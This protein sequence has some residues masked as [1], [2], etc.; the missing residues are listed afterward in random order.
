MDEA[1]DNGKYIETSDTTNADLKRFREFIYR[2]LKDKKYYDD[3]HPVS[4]IPACFFDTAKTH[5][6]NAIEEINV[7][8]LKLRLIIDQRGT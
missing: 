6:F 1:V 5:K 7:D 3:M 4:N 2:N 8:D